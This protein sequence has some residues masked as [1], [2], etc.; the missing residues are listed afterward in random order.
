MEYIPSTKRSVIVVELD[1]HNYLMYYLS[2]KT[3]RKINEKKSFIMYYNI[4][5]GY[6]NIIGLAI[7]I[8]IPRRMY[9]DIHD[10]RVEPPN[11]TDDTRKKSIGMFGVYEKGN[12][13]NIFE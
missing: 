11:F 1:G 10:D 12:S 3:K 8:W 4:G 6:I 9:F 5:K 13:L 2:R 7:A